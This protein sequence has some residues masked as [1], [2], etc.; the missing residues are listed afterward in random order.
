MC[1]TFAVELTCSPSKVGAVLASLG[2]CLLMLA[3]GTLHG[4]GPVDKLLLLHHWDPPRHVSVSEGVNI[5]P[6]RPG[7]RGDCWGKRI[8]ILTRHFLRKCPFTINRNG[9]SILDLLKTKLSET[10]IRFEADGMNVGGGVLCHA[11]ERLKVLSSW[12]GG[13][14]EPQTNISWFEHFLFL[15]ALVCEL[16]HLAHLYVLFLRPLSVSSR[17]ANGEPRNLGQVIP[18][19]G[20]CM[21]TWE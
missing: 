4:Y 21:L 15:D 8:R 2:S 9:Y 1:L 19:S 14:A 13:T 18:L 10:E 12:C 20:P 6:K 16:Q 11:E 7:L 17:S 3:L 5:D